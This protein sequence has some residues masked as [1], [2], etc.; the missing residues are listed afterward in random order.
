VFLAMTN[1]KIPNNSPV[2]FILQQIYYFD[3]VCRDL[4]GFIAHEAKKLPIVG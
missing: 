2:P 1:H 3:E 4:Y